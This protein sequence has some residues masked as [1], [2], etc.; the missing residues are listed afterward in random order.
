MFENLDTGRL[1]ACTLHRWSPGIGDPTLAG[2]L[3]VLAYA[4]CCV[5]A[6]K[7][8]RRARKG[9]ERGFWMLVTLAMAFLA[10]N[11]QLDLQSL[12]T[13]VA[14]CVAQAQGWYADR[15]GVQKEFIE[16]LLVAIAA[17]LGLALYLMR[18]HLRRNGLAVAGLVLVAGFVAIRAVSFHHFDSFLK[19]QFHSVR[20]NVILENSGLVLIALN[21]LFLL[22]RRPGR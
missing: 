8:T 14:R 17:V 22:R 18:R 20:F 1:E 21:A 11:K 10:L 16:G 5:L 7:V 6:F 9:R 15:R 3:T 12:L 13:S 4:L 19:G 2:W